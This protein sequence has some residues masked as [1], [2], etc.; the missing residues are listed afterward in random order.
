VV[1]KPKTISIQDTDQQLKGSD[2]ELDPKCHVI[3]T[4]TAARIVLGQFSWKI[5]RPHR[6]GKRPSAATNR[7]LR[8]ET[9]QLELSQLPYSKKA[10]GSWA[11]PSGTALQIRGDSDHELDHIAGCLS[12]LGIKS[13]Y[14]Y[15]LPPTPGRGSSTR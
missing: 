1:V 12:L 7:G 15:L 3:T 5:K 11:A 4:V 8:D 6:Y 13:L 14:H 9:S 2:V 10:P